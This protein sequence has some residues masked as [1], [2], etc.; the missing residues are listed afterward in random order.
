[1]LQEITAR[2]ARDASVVFHPYDTKRVVPWAFRLE[3]RT[4]FRELEEALAQAAGAQRDNK[5][6]YEIHLD[7]QPP[8]Y[9]W[10]HDTSV[11]IGTTLGD[12]LR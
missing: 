6:V 7:D 12:A 10:F 4:A 5:T 9:L 2:L 1:M 11:L 3:G 8:L